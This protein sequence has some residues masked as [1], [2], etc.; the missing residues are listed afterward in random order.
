MSPYGILLVGLLVALGWLLRRKKRQVQILPSESQLRYDSPWV[1]SHFDADIVGLPELHEPDYRSYSGLQWRMAIDNSLY[2]H[3]ELLA[4]RMSQLFEQQ[5]PIDFDAVDRKI[6]HALLENIAKL[7]SAVVEYTTRLSQTGPSASAYNN[8]GYALLILG[9]YQQAIPDF[10]EAIALHAVEAYA[11]NNRGFAY[12]RTGQPE[13]A[14]TDIEQSLQL[15]PGNSY[16]HRNL[17]IYYYEQGQLAPALAALEQAAALNADTPKL[18][19]YLRL[20]EKARAEKY[21]PE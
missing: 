21:P 9:N 12:L 6:Q 17:G 14:R 7:K 11:Y 3:G 4:L 2:Q 18:K 8:R 20:V 15:N 13:K 5:R 19:W 16:A 10:D 1:S